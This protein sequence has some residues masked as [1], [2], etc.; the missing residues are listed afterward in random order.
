MLPHER[1]LVEQL[2]DEP[3]ALIG[4]NSDGKADKVRKLLE[5]QD[6]AWRNA[7]DDSTVG[8]LATQWNVNGWPT[9]Y[10]I[11]ANGVIRYRDLHGQELEDAILELVAEA[12]QG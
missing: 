7:I 9:I 1:A 6:I 10:I 11:D 2:K 12:K 3:F 8:P 5:E 4:I